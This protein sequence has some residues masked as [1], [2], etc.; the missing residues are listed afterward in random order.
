MYDPMNEIE[1]LTSAK[2]DFWQPSQTHMVITSMSE[3]DFEKQF[4]NRQVGSM[5]TRVRIQSIRY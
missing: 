3:L 4:T 1:V 2:S 5:S